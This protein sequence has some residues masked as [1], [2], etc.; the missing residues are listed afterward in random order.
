M[1]LTDKDDL[2]YFTFFLLKFKFFYSNFVSNTVV[3]LTLFWTQYLDL[4]L[5]SRQEPTYEKAPLIL[6]FWEN[7]CLHNV[8]FAAL[9]FGKRMFT[10]TEACTSLEACVDIFCWKKSFCFEILISKYS[11]VY[12]VFLS[13]CIPNNTESKQ[14]PKNL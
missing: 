11:F 14:S 5:T 10:G 7:V 9:S 13:Y 4:L 3:S 6:L 1:L 2:L 12:K 8:C